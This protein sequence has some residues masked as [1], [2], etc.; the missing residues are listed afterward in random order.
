MVR[1]MIWCSVWIP[2][3]LTGAGPDRITRGVVVLTADEVN[4]QKVYRGTHEVFEDRAA[5]KGRTIALEIVVATALDAEPEPDP[6]FTFSGGPGI[7]AASWAYGLEDMTAIRRKREIVMISQRGTGASNG[8]FCKQIG[9]P[10]KL[11]TYL[12]EM[13]TEDYVKACREDLEQRADLRLYHTAIAM[14]DIDE[15]RA[16]MGYGKINLI[17]GSYGGRDVLAYLRRHGDTVRS[18]VAEWPSPPWQTI[19]AEF[20][21]DAQRALD[22]L[23]RDCAADAACAARFPDLDET[24]DNAFARFD[25]GPVTAT[26]QNPMTGEPETVSLTRGVFAT[27]IRALLYNPGRST[28]VPA[29]LEAAAKGDVTD[30]AR[31][32][33]VYTKSLDDALADG[34]YLSVTCAEDVPYMNIAKWTRASEGTFLG[35][36]RIAAQKRGCDHWPRGK[37]PA[38]YRARPLKSD[39]PV[40]IVSGELDPVTPPRWADQAAEGLTNAVHVRFKATAH[41]GEAMYTC[42]DP[43]LAEFFDKG[44]AEDIDFG[45]AKT[46]ERPPFLTDLAEFSA[47]AAKRLTQT[48]DGD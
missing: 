15:V 20:A 48:F 40:L 1:A 45:C 29:L 19:P 13:F 21:V 42:Y 16:A 9:N 26:V 17:G 7:A 32:I 30:M 47:D 10:K 25:E 44:T 18:A 8:L 38:T 24:A 43:L 4:G 5:A 33:A 28:A 14:D 36:Y 23:I 37:I 6:V 46:L 41:G 11:Q 12:G 3:V 2:A 31:F 27:G 35:D 22:L 34:M 39:V